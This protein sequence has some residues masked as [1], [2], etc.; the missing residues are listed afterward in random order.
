MKR[1]LLVTDEFG[2]GGHESA[3][4]IKKYLSDTYKFDIVDSDGFIEHVDTKLFGNPD[5]NK[6][7]KRKKKNP[8][9][10]SFEK[11]MNLSISER[12]DIEY[13]RGKYPKSRYDMDNLYEYVLNFSK[14]RGESDKIFKH[15]KKHLKSYESGMK[16]YDLYYLMFHSM[17]K[18]QEVV[19]L[20]DYGQKVVS[21]VAGFPT[22]RKNMFE[23]GARGFLKTANRTSGVFANSIKGL[24]DL[25]KIY[26]GPSYYV[27]HGV[28]ANIF[29]PKRFDRKQEF[30]VGYVGKPV[31]E[32]GLQDMIKP[33]C[34]KAGVRL[35][36]NTRNF[37]N[38]LSKEQ[39]NEFYNDIHVY[40]VASTIDGTPCPALESAAC[41][42]P[43]ISNKIGNMPE[44]IREGENGFMV[45]REVDAYVEK[46]K[47]MKNNT[48]TVQKMG[49]V[50]RQT[51]LDG[52]TW[53][54]VSEYERKALRGILGE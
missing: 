12:E 9:I 54:K 53:E 21:V 2:W 18:K 52:W 29:H 22:L 31:G 1:I 15:F 40:V 11:K 17:L 33:A 49:K 10:E 34:E 27:P 47:W 8:I 13:Y 19:K 4:N 44:F 42:R 7:L 23:E 30:T 50:A 25:R 28:D 3:L 43:I 6:F 14:E 39:M 16:F 48:G 51:V 5:A 24:K 45:E 32:K 41:G 26:G 20:L 37:E 36:A 38:A 35:L 46:I